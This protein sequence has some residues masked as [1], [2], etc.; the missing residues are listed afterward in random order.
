MSIFSMFRSSTGNPDVS[1]ILGCIVVCTYQFTVLWSIIK[2]G[3]VPDWSALGTGDGLMLAGVAA[4]IAGK[5]L[6]IAKAN[7]IPGSSQ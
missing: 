3:K 1:R 4:F 5:E 2:L 7:A 6:A